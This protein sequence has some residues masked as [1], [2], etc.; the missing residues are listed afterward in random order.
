MESEGAWKPAIKL[1]DSPS[2]IPN[3]GNKSVWRLYDIR[4]KATADLLSIDEDPRQAETLRLRHPSE[5]E[6][7]RTLRTAEVT[8]IEPLLT[9]AWEGKIVGAAPTWPPCVL[10]A[11]PTWPGS[12]QACDVS[13]IPTPITCR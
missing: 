12:I 10:C 9:L 7:S 2:K 13:S 6:V 4:G 8:A 5:A 1:S 11:M 3:P